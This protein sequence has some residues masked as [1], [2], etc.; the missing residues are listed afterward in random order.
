[1]K[2]RDEW[3]RQDRGRNEDSSQT[4]RQG[5]DGG[6]GGGSEDAGGG[7]GGW[8]ES[9]RAEPEGQSVAPVEEHPGQGDYGQSGYGPSGYN[10]GLNYGQGGAAGQGFEQ[11]GDYGGDYGGA[12]VYGHGGPGTSGSSRESYGGFGGG[13][14]RPSEGSWRQGWWHSEDPEREPGH[15]HGAA[16]GGGQGGHAGHAV[17]QSVYGQSASFGGSHFRPARP[18]RGYQRS[19]E[20]IREDLCEAVVRMGIDAGDVDI[21]VE[22]GVVTLTGAIASSSDKRG[23]EDVAESL[24]GVQ[25]VHSHLRLD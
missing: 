15:A 8:E 24:P 16:P 11:G 17:G 5:L 4:E 12:H 7:R 10:L 3:R 21:N 13:G 22:R 14:Y 1:M 20:R 2:N 6:Y 23:L 18:P 25:G 9:W 19:D